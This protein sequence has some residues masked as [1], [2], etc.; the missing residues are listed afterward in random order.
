MNPCFKKKKKKKP[1][2]WVNVIKYW[3]LYIDG[4]EKKNRNKPKFG[5]E[6][7]NVYSRILCGDY[8]MHLIGWMAL[9]CKIYEIDHG[10]KRCVFVDQKEQGFYN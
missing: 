1:T 7:N 3:E 8:T 2:L 5:G 6:K 4:V 10:I 9:T